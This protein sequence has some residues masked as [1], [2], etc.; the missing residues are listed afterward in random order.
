[1]LGQLFRATSP[2]FPTSP[3]SYFPLLPASRLTQILGPSVNVH[4][5]AHNGRNGEYLSGE[6]PGLGA[7]LTPQYVRGVQAEGVA[8]VVKHF[9]LNSQAPPLEKRRATRSVTVRG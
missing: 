1:M 2:Y 8:A 4:R 6:E 9:V 3:Y 7:K 5:V